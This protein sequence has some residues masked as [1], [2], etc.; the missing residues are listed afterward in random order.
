MYVMFGASKRKLFTIQ[1]KYHIPQVNQD[2]SIVVYSHNNENQLVELVEILKKQEYP[3]DKYK[4]NI[5]LDN[6]SDNSSNVLER[7]GGVTLWR[8]NTPDGP[9]GKNQSISWLLDKLQSNQNTNSYVFLNA[10]RTVGIDFL[11]NINI[12]LENQPLI[13]GSTVFVPKAGF[14]NE[15]LCIKNKLITEVVEAGRS[16]VGFDT[17][18]DTDVCALRQSV[19]EQV[20]F[21]GLGDELAQFQYSLLLSKYRIPLTYS[22]IVQSYL[23][24]YNYDLSANNYWGRKIGLLKDAYLNIF[25]NTSWRYK[26]FVLSFCKP[27]MFA[28]AIMLLFLMYL[29]AN[30]LKPLFYGYLA[31]LVYA[32]ATSKFNIKEILLL[33]ASY[34]VLPF[35]GLVR[36]SIFDFKPLLSNISAFWPNKSLNFKNKNS[37]MRLERTINVYITDGNNDLPGELVLIQEEGLNQAIFKFKSKKLSSEKHIRYSDAISQVS[38]KLSSHGF[39]L[40][41]CK[42]C[43]YFKNN[44]NGQVNVVE[45]LCEKKFAKNKESEFIESDEQISTLLW[46]SCRYI[47]PNQSKKPV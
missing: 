33:I 21:T 39:I 25:L 37:N 31:L 32:L 38:D 44:P 6:C 34:S 5:I 16:R 13:T 14:I 17:I 7:L 20:R 29:G 41:I 43:I 12:A 19:L 47:N 22:P 40:K 26:E 11:K 28:I 3:Q 42:N 30:H 10:N 9:L 36:G 18:L 45:G 35:Y 1:K 2:F 46:N 24:D 8:I 27:N 23:K 15:L 4:I